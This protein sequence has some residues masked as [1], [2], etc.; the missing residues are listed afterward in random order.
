MTHFMGAKIVHHTVRVL[1]RKYGL[2]DADRVFV[3]GT[4]AGGIGVLTNIDRVKRYLE[5]ESSGAVVRGIVDS[6]W[7][8]LPKQTHVSALSNQPFYKFYFFS[9]LK[10]QATPNIQAD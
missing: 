9:S 5:T 8:L 4:S 3:A 10:S 6:A 1:A 2:R 7:Y